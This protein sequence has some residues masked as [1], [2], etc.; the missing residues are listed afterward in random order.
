MNSYLLTPETEYEHTG[1]TPDVIFTCG[2]IADLQKRRL[3]VY[4]GGADTCIALAEGD[5]DEI[6]E[7]CL[8]GR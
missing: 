1:R 6:V 3:R 5:L 7:A 4:Y 8:E 2:G